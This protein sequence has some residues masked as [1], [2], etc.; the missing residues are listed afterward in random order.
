M[1]MNTVPF[2]H[3]NSDYFEF[4]ELMEKCERGKCSL[5]NMTLIH[6][7]GDINGTSLRSL[8]LDTNVLNVE[9]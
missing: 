9:T 4:K 3:S 8:L 7:D 2:A 6:N 1:E 5:C